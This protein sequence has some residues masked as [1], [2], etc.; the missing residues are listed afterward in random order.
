MTTVRAWK[1]LIRAGSAWAVGV[2]ATSASR[3][4]WRIRPRRPIARRVSAGSTT[5][6]SIGAI[7]ASWA[8]VRIREAEAMARSTPTEPA[9]SASAWARSTRRDSSEEIVSPESQSSSHTRRASSTTTLSPLRLRCA[10]PAAW[11]RR[12]WSHR[13]VSTA[14]GRSGPSSDSAREPAMWSVT[15]ST[16]SGVSAMPRRVGVR[17]PARR[18][19]RVMSAACSASARIDMPLSGDS[20][21]T[22]M[23][24]HSVAR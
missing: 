11:A 18:A 12:S 23:R 20:P 9:R 7:D 24:S 21:R 5:R 14:S 22:R 13:P 17:T 1:R 3:N 10:R 6:W 16:D 19:S 4:S 2:S 8:V 15:R